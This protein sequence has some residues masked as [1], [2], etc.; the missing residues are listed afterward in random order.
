MGQSKS[1]AGRTGRWHPAPGLK[2]LEAWNEAIRRRPSKENG[3]RFD[4]P[5]VVVSL[6]VAYGW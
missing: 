2:K 6:F 1:V 4:P 5:A 3:R